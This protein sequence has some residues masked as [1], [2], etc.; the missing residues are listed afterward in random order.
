MQIAIDQQSDMKNVL[1]WT[2]SQWALSS[3]SSV[4]HSLVIAA[5]KKATAT[6][7]CLVGLTQA[8]FEDTSLAAAEASVMIPYAESK[9]QLDLLKNSQG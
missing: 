7:D 8:S 9:A 3:A 2:H 5:A 4:C 1:C 6:L